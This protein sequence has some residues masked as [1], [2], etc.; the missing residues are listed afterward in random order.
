MKVSLKSD[1][2]RFVIEG[3]SN[4]ESAVTERGTA[5]DSAWMMRSK[6]EQAACSCACKMEIEGGVRNDAT[7][8]DAPEVAIDGSTSRSSAG[9]S[10][11][12]RPRASISNISCTPRSSI[13][14]LRVHNEL[15]L[16][17]PSVRDH[18]QAVK[19]SDGRETVTLTAMTCCGPEHKLI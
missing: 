3:P 16:S 1:H 2:T 11:R 12:D 18:K 10:S 17:L 9:T 8:V 5:K 19:Q 14:G 13:L 7:S 4:M 6:G 15:A